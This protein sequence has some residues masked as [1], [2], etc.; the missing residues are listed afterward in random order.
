MQHWRCTRRDN[1][2]IRGFGHNISHSRRGIEANFHL[3]LFHHTS[4]IIRLVAQHFHIFQMLIIA[5]PVHRATQSCSLFQQ[6][7]LVTYLA[8]CNR[9]LHSAGTTANYQDLLWLVGRNYSVLVLAA[10]HRVLG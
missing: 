1:N 10:E 2:H 5:R 3:P 8:R 9:V 7:Y 4:V 6:Q